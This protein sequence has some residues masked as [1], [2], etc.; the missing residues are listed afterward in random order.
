MPLSSSHRAP[1]PSWADLSTRSALPSTRRRVLEYVESCA[2]AVTALE[3]ATA[4]GLHHNTVREHLDALISAGFV[5]SHSRATGRRGRPSILYAS[6]A[7]DPEDVLD[8][9]LT[10]LDV[11]C[12]TIGTDEAGMRCAQEIGRRWAVVTGAP[13]VAPVKGRAGDRTD[14]RADSRELSVAERVAALEPHLSSMGFAPETDGDGGVLLRAC[15]LV[16]RSRVPHPLVCTMHEAFLN[17]EL[18]RND[19]AGGPGGQRPGQVELTPLQPD[20]CHL[21]LVD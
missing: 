14:G 1:R 19:A 13:P 15:P 8:S 11:V 10:L 18:R 4:L 9:Y 7:P 3:V 6:T 5:T 16:T 21:H 20:G 12:E 2:E 17:E